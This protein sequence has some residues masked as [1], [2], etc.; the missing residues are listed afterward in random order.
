MATT[1][2]RI[3]ISVSKKVRDA[4]IG[5]AKRDQMPTATKAGDLLELALDIEED[6]MLEAIVHTRDTKNVRW[7]SHA[8]LWSKRRTR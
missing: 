6:R 1:K 3:N 4:L 7:V 8:T 5:L 2:Q